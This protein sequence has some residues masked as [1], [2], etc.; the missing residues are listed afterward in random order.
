M[1][2]RTLPSTSTNTFKGKK[3]TAGK[4]I[5]IIAAKKSVRKNVTCEA[6]SKDQREVES[7]RKE[8]M[9]CIYRMILV[10]VVMVV[11]IDNATCPNP[12]KRQA[13]YEWLG[14]SIPHSQIVQILFSTVLHNPRTWRGLCSK[15]TELISRILFSHR[16]APVA[17]GGEIDDHLSGTVVT[18]SLKRRS[19]IYP[20]RP[21]TEVRI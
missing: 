15:V 5:K 9:N 11:I 1:T 16:P 20:A 18:G 6:R 4:G 13:N 2:V 8:L 19:G 17:Q 14:F 10:V 21:C 7:E 12:Q 3:G